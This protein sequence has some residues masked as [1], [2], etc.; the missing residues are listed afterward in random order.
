MLPKNK[1]SGSSGWLGIVAGTVLAS[2]IVSLDTSSEIHHSLVILQ[3]SLEQLK[4]KVP[5]VV[6]DGSRDKIHKVLLE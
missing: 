2:L 4:A 3:R 5:K 6:G 1:H